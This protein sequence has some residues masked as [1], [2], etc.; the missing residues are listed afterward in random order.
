MYGSD[1]CRKNEEMSGKSYVKTCREG[2]E[3]VGKGPGIAG[4]TCM[5]IGAIT[6]TYVA[7]YA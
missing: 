3:R 5:R 7:T 6:Y 2:R 4:C 1:V